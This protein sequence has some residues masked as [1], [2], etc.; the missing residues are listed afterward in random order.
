MGA[1]AALVI[2]YRRQR[3]SEAENSR[4][5]TRLFTERLKEPAKT[6]QRIRRS[7]SGWSPCS[8]AC[9][10]WCSQPRVTTDVYRCVVR[11]PVPEDA[12]KEEHVE[13]QQR[14]LRFASFREVRHTI[15]RIIG[16][17]LRKDA[18]SPGRAA[19]STSPGRF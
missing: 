13:H 7:P 4:K 16:R 15:I 6:R 1:V 9:G 10:R 18:L 11:L 2:N 12:S 19:T 17:R 8:G 3:L 5:E 14:T